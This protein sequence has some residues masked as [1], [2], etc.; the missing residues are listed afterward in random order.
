MA[1]FN[2]SSTRADVSPLPSPWETLSGSGLRVISN[3]IKGNDTAS[4][5]GYLA[6][7]TDFGDNQ[8]CEIAYTGIGGNDLPGAGARCQNSGSGLTGYIA[9]AAEEGGSDRVYVVKFVNGVATTISAPAETLVSPLRIEVETVGG[10]AQI[11]VTQNG[12]NIAGSPF[13]DSS[14]PI[15]G[16]QPAGFYDYGNTNA[17]S[18]TN[19]SGGDLSTGVTGTLGATESGADT[20]ASTGTVGSNGVRLTLRDTDTGALAASL[21]GLIVSI[22]ATSRGVEIVGSS[23]ETSDGSGVLEFTSGAIGSI[24]TYVYVTVEK[25][26]NSIVACYRVQVIDLNA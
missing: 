6:S 24:G 3:A 12:T 4:V 14:S 23:S 13:T 18:I 11:T 2:Y 21:T 16:G 1:T 26:D 19:I 10:D 17:T 5:S 20:L 25:S 7:V 8:F 9:Y 15:T 22:R